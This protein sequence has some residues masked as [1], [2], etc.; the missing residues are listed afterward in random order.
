MATLA[1][2]RAQY[3]QYAD[4]PDAA[5]ADA[6]HKKFYADMPRAEFDAKI[7]L[8][9]APTAAT[10]RPADAIPQQRVES[11]VWAAAR[12]YVEPVVTTGAMLG[13]AALGSL[14]GPAGTLMGGAG[15][16][17]AGEAALRVAD[18]AAGN[19]PAMTAGEGVQAGAKDL[20]MGAI[21]E[22]GGRVAAPFIEK[23]LAGGAK[24]LGWLYD[25][26]SGQLGQQKAARILR[27]SLG[28]DV[29][30][31]KELARSAPTNL[32]AAQ[33]IAD[34]TSPTTQALLERA[35]ARDP[36]YFVSVQEAQEAARLNQLAELA[37]GASQTAAKTARGEAKTTL[38][39]QLL[40][41]GELEL[42]TANVAGELEPALRAQAERMSQAAASKVQDV[43]RF[44]EAS[45]RAG[46]QAGKPQTVERGLPVPGRYTYTG[47]LAKRAEAVADEAAKGSLIF[48]EASRFATAA[49]DSLAAHGLKPLKTE[50]IIQS[51]NKTLND[52]KLAGNRD[53]Q[54]ALTRVADDIQQWTNLGGVVDAFALDSIRKNS[55]NA[56]VRQM[57]PAAD[58]KAQK[59]L[60]A[61]VLDKVRPLITD[62]IENA[63][64]TGY[65]A[66]L[67]AYS[68]RLQAVS[69][70]RLSARA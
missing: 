1:E 50:P 4:M 40:P 6:L 54:T 11:P 64:G 33:S 53:V 28:M 44:T 66:Y 34:L 61:K 8:T 63:G 26:L 35:A 2:I 23:A 59:E 55:V 42:R 56:V 43:R 57:Y 12:P 37:G 46:A 29:G 41:Q 39:N 69:Q 22:A 36:R 51:I 16:Y 47:E 9:A 48:G 58:A 18:Q 65:K 52:P 14:G 7:G 25:T 21:Y 38:R 5:L 67:E 19:A 10:A 24:G 17:A 60:A 32:T 31:A 30:A 62:A 70:Q 3:P 13:G 49:A 20:L 15:G 45:E 68:K 27:E